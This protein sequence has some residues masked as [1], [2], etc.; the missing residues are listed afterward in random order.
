MTKVKNRNPTVIVYNYSMILLE[1]LDL[2]ESFKKNRRWNVR[3]KLITVNIVKVI[4]HGKAQ[5][6]I[7]KDNF[8][9]WKLLNIVENELG[10]QI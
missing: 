4:V 6:I 3:K 10:N 7:E 5:Y 9:C 1:V 2:T 8:H